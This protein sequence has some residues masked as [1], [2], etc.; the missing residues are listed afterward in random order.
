[1]KFVFLLFLSILLNNISLAF[2]S[3]IPYFYPTYWIV[4]LFALGVY[5]EGNK[6]T[7]YFFIFFAFLY[8]LLFAP[9]FGI[10]LFSFLILFSFLNFYKKKISFNLW[11]YLLGN[12]LSIFVYSGTFFLLLNIIGYFEVP[13]VLY[14]KQ[15][16]NSL[17]STIFFSLFCYF[18]LYYRRI[19]QMKKSVNKKR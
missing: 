14:L 12:I 13:L 1:M 10:T 3:Q 17:L 11:T 18:F 9:F 8:D 6:K 5:P 15:I 19:L 2:L 16:S 4:F 7:F